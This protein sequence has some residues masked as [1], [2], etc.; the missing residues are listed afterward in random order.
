MARIIIVDDK[1]NEIGVKDRD[2]A[3]DND[4]YRVTGL[5]LTNSKGEILIAQRKWNKKHNPGC[6]GPAVAGTVEEGETY[7]TN[8][9]KEIGE[10][11]GIDPGLVTLKKGPYFFVSQGHN[12]FVQYYEGS[13]DL[14]VEDFTPQDIEVEQVKWITKPELEKS[15]AA[16]PSEYTPS[17]K[18]M[19][20]LLY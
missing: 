19:L 1:D 11:L 2:A 15:V 8:I 4:I 7:D 9:E 10:E 6:W 5:W 20:D 3:K 17:I 13:C 12:K 18:R 14:R 16:K